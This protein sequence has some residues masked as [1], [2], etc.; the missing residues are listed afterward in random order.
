VEK[1]KLDDLAAL[2]DEMLAASGGPM[3]SAERRTAD[4][5]LGLAPKT[6]KRR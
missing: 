1:T 5:R 2:L 6:R 4:R 3:T